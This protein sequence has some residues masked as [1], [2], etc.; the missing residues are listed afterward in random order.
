MFNYLYHEYLPTFQSNPRAND[1][2][3]EAYCLVNG[4]IPH[5][6]PSQLLGAGPALANGGFEAWTNGVPDG[7]TRVPG[8]RGEVW[9]GKCFRDVEE[10]RAGAAAIRLENASNDDVVQVSQNVRVGGGFAAGRKY[11]VVAWMKTAGMRKRNA[12]ALAALT[13]GVKVLGGWRLP[14]PAEEQGWAKGVVEF[15]LPSGADF[16]RVMLYLRGKGRVW[17]DDVALE[18]VREDGSVVPVQR[19]ETPRDHELM[20]QW[21]ELFAGPGRPYLLLGKMLPPPPLETAATR[22]KDSPLPPLLHNAYRAPDGGE[23]VV[24]VNTTDEDQ[25]AT[26]HWHG[27]APTVRLKPWEVILV[28]D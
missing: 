27:K 13:S 28:K 9:R 2:L 7:W 3:V 25:T 4:E 11:R 10:R 12:L 21:V 15:T 1:K 14:F 20:R 22:R 16:L 5:F 17:I 23:A 24:I 8:Y 6:T 19:P 26:L 18:E